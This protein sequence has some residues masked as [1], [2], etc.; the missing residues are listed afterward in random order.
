[1]ITGG[2]IDEVEGK[3]IG[4]SNTI[5]NLNIDIALNEVKINGIN[6]EVSY[7]YTALYGKDKNSTHLTIKGAIFAEE[8]KKLVKEIEDEWK[9]AKKLPEAYAEVVINAINYTGIANGTLLA[10]LLNVAP[11]LIPPRIQLKQNK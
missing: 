4:E 1:M 2:R 8:D 10:R 5:T 7:T 9:K 3:K 6:L 11:P